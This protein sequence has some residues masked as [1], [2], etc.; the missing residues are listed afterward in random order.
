MAFT[1]QFSPS[2]ELT[3][4]LPGSAV[5]GLASRGLLHVM[6]ELQN[7]GSDFITE[8]DLAE[9]FGRNRIEPRF[10][11]TFRTAVKHSAIHQVADLA[12]LVIEYGAGPTVRRSLKEP[13]YGTLVLYFNS[14]F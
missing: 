7:S 8:G 4:F 6:R 9:I 12:E 11:S 10:A 14:A 2:L 3:K 5:V 13:A 1:N